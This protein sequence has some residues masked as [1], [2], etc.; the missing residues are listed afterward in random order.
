MIITKMI[1]TI[2]T[3]Y[4]LPLQFYLVLAKIIHFICKNNIMDGKKVKL[5]VIWIITVHDLSSHL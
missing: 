4:F 2:T 1:I 3:H 5:N